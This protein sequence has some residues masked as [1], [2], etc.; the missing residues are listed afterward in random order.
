MNILEYISSLVARETEVYWER[1]SPRL[2]AAS[3]NGQKHI[4]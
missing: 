4:N 2:A 3:G 1:I